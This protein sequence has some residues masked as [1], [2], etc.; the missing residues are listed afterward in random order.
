MEGYT[1][2]GSE[3]NRTDSYLSFRLGDEE[4]AAH[5]SKVLNILEMTR[6]TRVPK[7]PEYMKGV[8]NL[9]GMVLPVID[10]RIKFGM[11]ETEYTD[12]TCIVVMDLDLDG[13]LVH[14]GALV[15]E[16]VAVLEIEKEQIEPPPSIGNTYR[17]DFISGVARQ[18][19]N[20]IMII[21]MIKIF[22]TAEI[23]SLVKTVDKVKDKDKKVK[24]E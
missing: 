13:E 1:M 19:D 14:V 11:P 15:D 24:S 12:K 17:S 21:D 23:T 10:T 4:Y 18:G 9:R 6:I 5:V 22:S 7:A 8:I 16:V 3:M 2:I 20:F